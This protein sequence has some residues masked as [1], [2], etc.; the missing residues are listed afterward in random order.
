MVI[1]GFCTNLQ[2]A[3]TLDPSGPT[4]R[5]YMLYEFDENGELVPV[6]YSCLE[7]IAEDGY[8]HHYNCT[9]SMT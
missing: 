8:P 5:C 6:D 1:A 9:L 4:G 3:C 2:A 7:S